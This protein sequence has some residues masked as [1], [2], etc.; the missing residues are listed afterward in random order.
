M[1]GLSGMASIEEHIGEA[2]RLS[3]KKVKSRT[4]S[5]SPNLPFLFSSAVT[6]PLPGSTN[7]TPPELP[8]GIFATAVSAQNGQCSTA[9]WTSYS[10]SGI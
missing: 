9:H 10:L 1:P 5:R 6:V 2:V 8:L 3:L 7:L 4:F